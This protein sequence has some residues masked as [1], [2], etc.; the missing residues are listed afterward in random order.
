MGYAVDAHNSKNSRLDYEY[1][2]FCHKSLP[3]QGAVC[4]GVPLH[5]D[6][7][8]ANFPITSH[9]FVIYNPGPDQVHDD[10]HLSPRNWSSV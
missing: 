10:S 6:N 1:L 7:D 4:A 3:Y 9:L 5:L 8:Q 2:T